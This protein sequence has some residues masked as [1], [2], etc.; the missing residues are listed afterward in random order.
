MRQTLL[1]VPRIGA[2]TREG[3]DMRRIALPLGL[4]LAV[5]VAVPVVAA[6]AATYHGRITAGTFACDATPATPY[7][8]VEGTWN[9]NVG[10]GTA[11]VTINVFYDGSHH[12]SFGMNGGVVVGDEPLTVTFGTARLMID[13]DAFVWST[14]AGTCGTGHPYDQLTYLGDLGR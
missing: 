12:L 8:S 14:P 10:G 1:H 2:A 6:D 4:L 5:A 7:E 11:V 13:G 3:S 9:L